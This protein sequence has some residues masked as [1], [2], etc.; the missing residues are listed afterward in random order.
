MANSAYEKAVKLA[1]AAKEGSK[2]PGLDQDALEAEYFSTL[3]EGV[4]KETVVA[5]ANHE[6][7]WGDSFH[8]YGSESIAEQLRGRD[9]IDNLSI[10]FNTPF[11]SY[12]VDYA[13]VTIE[14][15]TKEDRV[16][17]YSL[18]CSVKSEDNLLGDV[19]SR[20]GNLYEDA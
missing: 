3:P 6:R 5:I 7:D 4:T 8:R 17:S 20:I 18:R 1:L 2:L 10:E 12:A 14:N 15:P 13:R 16:N 9:D 19:R 11:A